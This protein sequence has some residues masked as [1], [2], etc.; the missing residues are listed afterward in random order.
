[1]VKAGSINRFSYA[2]H[3]EVQVTGIEAITGDRLGAIKIPVFSRLLAGMAQ[4]GECQ[5]PREEEAYR[6]EEQQCLPLE[7][8][9]LL[10]R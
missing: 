8:R 6:S 1:M 9:R 2:D 7:V 10:S 3:A 4:A 5:D